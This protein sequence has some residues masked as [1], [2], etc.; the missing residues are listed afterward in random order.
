MNRKKSLFQN[1]VSFGKGFGKSVLK[2]A[3]SFKFKVAFPK[4]RTCGSKVLEKPQK[5][6]F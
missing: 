1:S 5:I 2:G 6:I 4:T 3:F